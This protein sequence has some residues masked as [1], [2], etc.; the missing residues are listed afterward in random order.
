MNIKNWIG[1]IKPEI[2]DDESL[3]ITSAIGK[4]LDGKSNMDMKGL[5]KHGAT[6][7]RFMSRMNLSDD[8]VIAE[9]T[10]FR[11]IMVKAGPYIVMAI[12]ERFTEEYMKNLIERL[13]K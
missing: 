8:V 13:F 3:V 5:A 1:L 2:R 6:I 12:G 4:I 7:M 11:L 10:N 9:T